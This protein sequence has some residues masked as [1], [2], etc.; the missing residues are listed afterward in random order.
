M[1]NI[2]LDNET[3]RTSVFT[4]TEEKRYVQN[5]GHALKYRRAC[6]PLSIFNAW[7]GILKVI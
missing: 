1:D 6:G 2:A 4:A 3:Y 5:L 7:Q